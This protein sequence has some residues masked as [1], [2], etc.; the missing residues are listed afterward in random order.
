MIAHG[1]TLE[2]PVCGIGWSMLGHPDSKWIVNM[3]KANG[4][5][6]VRTINLPLTDSANPGS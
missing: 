1:A 5:E 6:L 3:I 4:T 2:E